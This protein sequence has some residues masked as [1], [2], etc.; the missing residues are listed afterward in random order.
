MI[1]TP[2]H[3]I[4]IAITNYLTVEQVANLKNDLLLYK[5]L[6]EMKFIQD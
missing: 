1:L 6:T 3:I 4:F 5:F 2:K